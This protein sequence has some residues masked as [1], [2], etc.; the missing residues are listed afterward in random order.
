MSS[1]LHCLQFVMKLRIVRQLRTPEYDQ[2]FAG[3]PT[4]GY[5]CLHIM[6][7]LCVNQDLVGDGAPALPAL[8]ASPACP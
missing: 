4:V 2:L 7:L 3:D 1:L 5:A 6:T 8:L